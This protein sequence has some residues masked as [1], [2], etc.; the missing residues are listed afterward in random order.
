[1]GLL[2]GKTAIIFGLANKDS[3]AWGITQALHREGA[4]IGISYAA[5]DSLKRRVEPLAESLGI[6]FVEQCDVSKDEDLDRTF[7][8]IKDRFGKIDILIHSVAFAN[9]E[10]ITGQFLPTSRAGFHTAMDISVYSLVAMSQRAQPL[11]AEGGTILAMSYYGS[12][13]VMPHYNVMGVAKAALEATVR[14][15]AAD[16]GPNNIRVNAISAG[17]IKTLSGAG[18]AGF[19]EMLRFSREA[20]PLK[21]LVDQDD[22]GNAAVWLCS[23]Y[24]N[25]I[26]GEVIYVD[27]GIN[28][29][30]LSLELLNMVQKQGE[31][32]S[33]E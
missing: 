24:A 33:A 6:D 9:R 30:G 21:K 22:V 27:A 16:L 14:Y 28:V 7:A 13:K 23:D 10:D 20:A 11:M 17:A 3:I 26:T 32:S 12:Q 2:S 15:L 31:D 18:I 25:V 19:R 8:K 1:M 29:M 4:T 5:I